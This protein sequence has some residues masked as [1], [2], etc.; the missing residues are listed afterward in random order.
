MLDVIKRAINERRTLTI[1]YPPGLRT[2][3]PHCLGMSAENNLLLRAYQTAGASAS[4][5]HENWK[6]LRIDRICGV[7]EAGGGFPGPRPLYNPNDK[8]MK[9]GIIARL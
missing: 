6:L 4:G 9:R 2:I 7:P 1:D 3:E 8:A 5:E